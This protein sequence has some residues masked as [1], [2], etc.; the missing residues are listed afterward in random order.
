MT[1][2][3]ALPIYG[4]NFKNL[5]LQNQAADDRENLVCSICGSGP[6]K[7]IEMMVLDWPWPILQEGQIWSLRLVYG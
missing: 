5:F 2:M 1:K 6:I 7:L 3:A 4:K